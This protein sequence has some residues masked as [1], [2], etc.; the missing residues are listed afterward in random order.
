M[1]KIFCC[2]TITQVLQE[3]SVTV[4]VIQSVDDFAESI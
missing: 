2:A 1:W 4:I 3:N